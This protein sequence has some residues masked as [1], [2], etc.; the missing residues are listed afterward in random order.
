[1]R[2][3]KGWKK[4]GRE[5]RKRGREGGCEGGLPCG[6][7]SPKMTMRSVDAK[8]PTRPLVKSVGLEGRERIG[9]EDGMNEKNVEPS[10]P[11]GGE[12][13]YESFSFYFLPSLPPSLPSSPH[14]T[15]KWRSTH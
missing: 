6:M 3:E 5:E 7:M 13:L 10:T 12:H 1:M 8:K 14:L 9:E 11:P 4:E 15:S 2:L